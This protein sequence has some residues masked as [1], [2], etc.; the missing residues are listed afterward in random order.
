PNQTARC[1]RQIEADGFA[2]ASQ[3]IA[4][5]GS[6]YKKRVKRAWLWLWLL[7]LP[8]IYPPLSQRPN[9]GVA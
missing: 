5:F 6:G 1:I 2:S 7:I 3:P 4:A 8:L 9:A